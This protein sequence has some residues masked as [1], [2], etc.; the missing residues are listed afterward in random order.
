METSQ[1]EAYRPQPIKYSI[2]CPIPGGGIPL[3]GG[4][5]GTLGHTSPCPDLDER[6]L[7]TLDGGRYLRVPPTPTL[8]YTGGRYLVVPPDLDRGVG[9][10]MGVGTL[11]GVGR[12]LGVAPKHP[13]LDVGIGTLGY[14]LP[15]PDALPDRLCCYLFYH[16]SMHH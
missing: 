14:P 11:V 5:V 8:T 9:T 4:G 12:Y 2:S 15:Y 16:S 7:E 13:D 1:K 10:L 3:E 6:G